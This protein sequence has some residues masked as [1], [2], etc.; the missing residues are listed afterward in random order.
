MAAAGV[1]VAFGSDDVVDPW[2]PLGTANPML[3][4]HSGV[5]AAQMTG[6]AEIAET[7]EMVSSRGARVLGVE[8][9]Y[10]LEVGR[11]ASFVVVPASSRMDAVR[12]QAA[13][14]WVVSHGHVVSERDPSPVR[15]QWRGGERQIDFVR[16]AD[17]GLATWRDARL[18]RGV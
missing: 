17:E 3:L 4:A 9:R 5:L 1:N 8:E 7:F 15:V 12:R 13:P 2:F 10:G 11:P 14:R 16:S 6:Q 18:E